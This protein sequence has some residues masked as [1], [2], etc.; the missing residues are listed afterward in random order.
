MLFHGQ[1]MTCRVDS[2]GRVMNM[3]CPI[4]DMISVVV[5]EQGLSVVVFG[6]HVKEEHLFCPR[7]A[8][9]SA[10]AGRTMLLHRLNAFDV[11]VDETDSIQS[12][13]SSLLAEN[14]P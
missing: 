12:T 10:W 7:F 13:C 8:L 11:F 1:A 4:A 6:F 9:S 5:L 2:S 3:Q 14:H